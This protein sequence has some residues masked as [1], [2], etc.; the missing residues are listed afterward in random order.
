MSL[1]ELFVSGQSRG[2]GDCTTEYKRDCGMDVEVKHCGTVTSTT[3]KCS[4]TSTPA[5]C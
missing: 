3:P 1:A 4:T 2:A 5:G